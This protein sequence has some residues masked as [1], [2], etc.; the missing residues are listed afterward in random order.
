MSFLPKSGDCPGVCAWEKRPLSV[1]AAPSLWPYT[2]DFGSFWHLFSPSPLLNS[3]TV[4]FL[5]FWHDESPSEAVTDLLSLVNSQE[6]SSDLTAFSKLWLNKYII[7]EVSMTL[8]VDKHVYSNDVSWHIIMTPVISLFSQYY[9]AINKI[10][11]RHLSQSPW[12]FTSYNP[13]FSHICSL[14]PSRHFSSPK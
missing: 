4:C 12:V 10:S 1:A 7:N 2:N 13:T 6:D 9:L 8:P 11:R 3:L 14:H 5:L